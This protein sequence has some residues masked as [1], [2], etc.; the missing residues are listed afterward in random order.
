MKSV[1]ET[2]VNSNPDQN[3]RATSV[4]LTVGNDS[5]GQLGQQRSLVSAT[6]QRV[7]GVSNPS[8]VICSRQTSFALGTGGTVWAWGDNSYGQCAQPAIFEPRPVAGTNWGR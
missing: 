6:P 1:Q 5:N 8:R 4:V 7:A 3:R 2:T